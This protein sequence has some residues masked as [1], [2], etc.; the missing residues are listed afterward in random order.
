MAEIRSTMDMVMERA[1]RMAAE[2]EE[3]SADDALTK[4][5]SP[6]GSTRQRLCQSTEM[7]ADCRT[8]HSIVDLMRL[9]QKWSIQAI[10]R[11]KQDARSR[12]SRCG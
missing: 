10:D 6:L 7:Q 9:Q 4:Q 1:A 12:F 2:A 3:V 5:T 11:M 8:T